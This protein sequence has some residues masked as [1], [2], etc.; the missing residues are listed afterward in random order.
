MEKNIPKYLDINEPISERVEDLLSRMTS[1]EKIAQLSGASNP[2]VLKSLAAGEDFPAAGVGAAFARTL[3]IA[4]TDAITKNSR[5]KSRL[6]IPTIVFEESLHGLYRADATVFPQSIGMGATFNDELAHRCASVIGREA[7]AHGIRQVLAP[8][9]DLSRDPRWGRVEENYGEDPYLTARMGTAYVKGLQQNGV[10]ATVKH[11]AAHGSPE[12]GINIA[13][14]HVGEREWRETM[15]EPFAAAVGEGGALS[16]MP[17]YSELDGIPMHANR[18]MLTDVLRGEL[19]F[20]G[21]VFSDFGGI[22]MMMNIH[23]TASSY[24]ECGVQSINAGVDMEATA[25]D[26][27]NSALLDSIRDGLVDAETLDNAVRRILSVKFRLGLFENSS[28]DSSL[29]P[30]VHSDESIALSLEAAEESAVLLKNN[31]ILPL[32]ENGGKILLVGVNA[33][34]PQLGDYSRREWDGRTVTLRRALTEVCGDNLI[35]H[36]GCSVA[37]SDPSLADAIRDAES[38]DVIIAVLGDNSGFLG[39]IGWGDVTPSTAVTCGEGF[40]SSSLTLPEPQRELLRAMHETGK[41]VV[42]I[43]ESGRPY[44]IGEEC[45]L[46]D[47]VIEAWYPG[48]V[49]GY[50]LANLLLGKVSPSGKLPISI[51]RSAGHVPCFY[52][53]KRSA[54]GFY[55]MHG[56]PDQP[57]RDYV[58]S[59]PE[60]LFEFGYGLSYTTFVYSDLTVDAR[61]ADEILVSVKVK[62]TGAMAAKEAVLLYISQDFCPVSPFVKRLRRFRKI[63][64]AV[65]EEKSVAFTLGRE[66]VS[67]IGFDMKPTV[68]KGGFTIEIGGLTAN[69]EL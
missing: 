28:S 31:G 61:S 51:P 60:P 7:R 66:D 10:A 49:G 30:L 27:F 43:I 18:K 34:T 21:Y 16:V 36:K 11:Y 33:D 46:S 44:C 54:R 20:D 56:S 40:D 29:V 13:P 19:G 37:S 8:C 38:A 25:H 65:G 32:R 14:V 57:G 45:S 17:A 1:E 58:F 59:S 62:N 67:Y 63:S 4:E 64:L 68:G 42:L 3:D 5:E 48:E 47:A 39:G 23:R 52:N 50:A 12:G 53:H 15:I 69:F 6:G 55:N 22:S 35:Y 41:P 26:C 24:E 2:G 9:V